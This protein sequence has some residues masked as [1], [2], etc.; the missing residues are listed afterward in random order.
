MT[1]KDP[2]K[3]IR[4]KTALESA[5]PCLRDASIGVVYEEWSLKAILE[6]LHEVGLKADHLDPTRDDA[7]D[8]LRDY[9]IVFLNAH[10]EYG[11]DGRIQGL[12][13]YLQLRYTHCGVLAGS[14]GCDK[15]L[16]KAVFE[17]LD[18]PTPR[19]WALTSGEE[20]TPEEE[21]NFPAMLKV[22][23]GGS[24][25]GMALVRSCEEL[26]DH[27]ERFRGAGH[28][29]LLIEEFVQGRSFTVGMLDLP[30]GT[31]VLP[32]LECLSPGDYYDE[33]A[34][35]GRDSDAKASYR[36]PED[37]PQEVLDE[38]ERHALAVYRRLGCR[39]AA[40][41]DFVV[42]EPDHE[43]FALEVNTI[44]GLQKESNL[45]VACEEVGLTYRDIV[46]ALLCDAAR[47]PN[48]APWRRQAHA[49]KGERG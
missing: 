12:L 45:V 22:S 44:P 4:A 6:C 29:R 17:Q 1:D 48:R 13:D 30:T 9:D 24:S 8:R 31:E 16:S 19:F 10:G 46:L 14:V 25:V 2:Q 41:V 38:M 43:A 11:E 34:K 15:I 5:L 26:E 23:N 3:L 28:E 32:P 37:L 20:G 40:R 47:R 35:L 7:V 21:P 33:E 18:V 27:I 49:V 39:G 42:R 36:V